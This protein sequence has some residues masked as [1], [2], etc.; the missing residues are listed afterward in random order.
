[1][2]NISQKIVFDHFYEE[3]VEKKLQKD[4]QQQLRNEGYEKGLKE[5]EQKGIA[6]TLEGIEQ[7]TLAALTIFNQ[8]YS[9]L[10]EE[11]AEID[12]INSYNSLYLVKKILSKTLTPLMQ[13]TYEERFLSLMNDVW[14]LIDDSHQ[15]HINTSPQLL[16]NFQQLF[17]EKTELKKFNDRFILSSNKEYSAGQTSITWGKNRIED[18]PN[19]VLEQVEK[20][21]DTHLEH[22]N[23]KD[24]EK[25][26]DE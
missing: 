11:L 23:L 4:K 6:I 5:G 20:I 15:I 13:Q 16:E 7:Q 26:D 3:D 2:T 18:H 12:Q 10:W 24:E 25:Q 8:Q 9:R 21:I 1:M 14:Q 19:N 22:L 17:G